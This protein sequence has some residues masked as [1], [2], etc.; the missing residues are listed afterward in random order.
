MPYKSHT[1]YDGSNWGSNLV[2]DRS[3]F[4]YNVT[5]ARTG[6]DLL[7]WLPND[8]I[9]CNYVTAQLGSVFYCASDRCHYIDL[10]NDDEFWSNQK[11]ALMLI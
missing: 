5:A 9:T 2:H 11:V 3:P 8:S 6:N 7:H 1:N 4:G 10:V